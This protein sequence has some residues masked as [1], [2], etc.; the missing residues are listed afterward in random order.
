MRVVDFI[1][2]SGRA[3]LCP[4]FKHFPKSDY[5][6]TTSSYR[7]YV[8]SLSKELSRGIDYLETRPDL[9]SGR[10]G[11]Y[12]FS[13]GAS[14]GAILPALEKRIKVSVLHGGGFYIQRG[15]PEVEQINFAPRVTIPVLMLNGRYDFFNPVE[16]SQKPMFRLLGTP[17][18]YKHHAIFE[19]GHVIP[20]NDAIRETLSWFDRY[21]GPVKR[22]E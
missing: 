3:L 21:L 12:G 8:I 18:E 7:D 20:R 17:E 2:K 13:W 5:P 14:M 6:D 1:I 22:R 16:A 15:R 11:Y 19:T 9:D 4:M 10:I